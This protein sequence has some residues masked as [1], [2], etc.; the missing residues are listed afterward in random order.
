MGEGPKSRECQGSEI[1]GARG[2]CPMGLKMA[3]VAPSFLI[4]P[5]KI[6]GSRNYL[7]A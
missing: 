5:S 3:K 7:K 2:W 1:Q 6:D 4:Q